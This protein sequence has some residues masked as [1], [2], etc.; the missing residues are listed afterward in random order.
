MTR[1]DQSKMSKMTKNSRASA[2]QTSLDQRSMTSGM[3][4]SRQGKSVTKSVLS[5]GSALG[6]K[7]LKNQIF[8]GMDNDSKDIIGKYN[9]Q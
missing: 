1:D 5:G 8:Q 3:S 9:Q 7:N 2:R 6:N 4:K